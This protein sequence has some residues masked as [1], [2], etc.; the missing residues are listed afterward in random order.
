MV[1]ETEYYDLL[2]VKPDATPGEIKKAYYVQVGGAHG[3]LFSDTPLS[4]DSSSHV[5][6]GYL[7]ASWFS[8]SK[9]ASR[10]EP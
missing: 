5:S 1:K 9:S 8:G 6:L 10:Q 2:G 3:R 4:K 7:R